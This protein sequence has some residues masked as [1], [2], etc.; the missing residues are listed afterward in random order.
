MPSARWRAGP[1]PWR[2]HAGAALPR[3][4][5]PPD[6]WTVG[7]PPTLSEPA[8]TLESPV[9]IPGGAAHHGE[10]ERVA[11]PPVELRHVVEVHPPDARDHRRHGDDGR[12]AGELLGDLV[13]AHGDEREVGFERTVEQ[14]AEVVGRLV[15]AKHGIADVADVDAR[16][17]AD[18]A[19]VEATQ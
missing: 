19:L 8:F 4:A 13:L 11:E 2:W 16:V 12:P 15:D 6:G 9:E 5:R 18:A 7:R 14:R 3:L 10:G 1:G 17:L